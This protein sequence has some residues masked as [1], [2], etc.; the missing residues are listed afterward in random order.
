[1]DLAHLIKVARG[2]EPADLVLKGGQVVN[3]FSGELE[4]VDLAISGDRI[5]G[6]GRYQ[7]HE[8][9][10]VTGCYLAPGLID[11]HLHVESSMVAPPELAR[12]V[13]PRGTTALVAD[14]HEI[15]NVLGIP[16]I[17]FLIDASVGLPLDIFFMAPSCVPA[18]HLETS[19]ARLDATD[20]KQLLDEPRILGLAEV[21]NFPGVIDGDPEVLNKLALFSGRPID[22]HAPF[23]S[24]ADLCA[25]VLP[26][27]STDHEC[28]ALDEARE[29]LARGQ[30]IL[31]REGSEAKNLDA[32]LALVNDHNYRR[33]AFCTDDRHPEDLIDQGHL[34]YILRRAV[35]QGLDPVRALTMA[36][37][38]PAETYGLTR[39]G[40]LAPG[41]L[42]DVVVFKSLENF[43]AIK[44]FKSGRLVAENG[45][46]TAPL[47]TAAVPDWAGPMNVAPLDLDGLVVPAAGPRARA[48]ELI[49]GQLLTGHL[50]VDA[51]VL[52]GRLVSD[53]DRDLIRM[54]VVERHSGTGNVG[55][56]LVKGFGF[57]QGAVA[58]SVAHDSH[59]IVAAG[60]S[61]EELLLAVKTVERMR[62][63]LVVVAANDIL[64]ELPLP[65]AG[66]MSSTSIEQTARAARN[67]KDAAKKIGGRIENP[68]MTLA[69]M[70]LPVIPS[71]KLTDKGLVDVER[72]EL[73]SLFVE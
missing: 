5:A 37:L 23:L 43:E 39:R 49:P 59:N 11:P 34:D 67:L 32:L 13:V 44:V 33:A 73:T 25:Y 29:K 61:D 53:I 56:G 6:L 55:Q 72:F 64:A 22:G 65:L 58:S 14:P 8:E 4:L 16:G 35:S 41:Y 17:R 70:A 54:I 21:M 48:I 2:L 63:G 24:G 1:M 7:G 10:D 46:L 36:T 12:A 68:F 52:G 62:G 3:V 40:A 30:R 19:G 27:I 57:K 20:L 15:A 69:F 28:S 38:N 42:A 9:V 60:V 71:L 45:E 50:V 66:L 51:P 31:I 47:S 26:G 18:T